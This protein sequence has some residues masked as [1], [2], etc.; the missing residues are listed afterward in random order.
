MLK[1]RMLCDVCDNKKQFKVHFFAFDSFIKFWFKKTHQYMNISIFIVYRNVIINRKQV[2]W[3]AIET[4][5]S[6]A[7]VT[8]CQVMR[9]VIME[10]SCP[11]GCYI[12][13]SCYNNNQ[14]KSNII[15]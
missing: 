6:E 5:A 11:L 7:S 2:G 8:K 1:D 13:F 15:A 12:S 3:L 10:V 9:V 14:Y 4:V